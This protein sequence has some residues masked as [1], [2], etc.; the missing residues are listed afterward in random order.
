MP[1]C[2]LLR[3]RLS[4]TKECRQRALSIRSVVF[5]GSNIIIMV[6]PL[7][8]TKEEVIA[9]FDRVLTEMVATL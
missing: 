4:F 3:S 6:P 9:S 5:E 7:I 2:K 1:R 8:V